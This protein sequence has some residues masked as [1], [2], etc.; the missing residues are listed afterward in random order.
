MKEL[1]IIEDTKYNIGIE[2]ELDGVGGV[3]EYLS[4]AYTP[5]N[6][7]EKCQNKPLLAAQCQYCIE[8]RTVAM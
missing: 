3:R 1:P 6:V 5:E 4:A 8:N 7:D 2:P